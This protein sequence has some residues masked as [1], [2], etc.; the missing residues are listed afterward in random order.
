MGKFREDVGESLYLFGNFA[1]P[2]GGQIP[3]ASKT[4]EA[5]HV[6]FTPKGG[7]AALT[8]EGRFIR[9]TLVRNAEQLHWARF[10]D[11]PVVY[12]DTSGHVLLLGDSCHAFCPSLGQGA[13][14]SIEDACVAADELLSAVRTAKAA[15]TAVTAKDDNEMVA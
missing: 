3:E 14:T 8:A 2:A 6:M 4:A 9:E 7:E 13:T 10:Q 11:I 15:M 5:M 1:I 12:S